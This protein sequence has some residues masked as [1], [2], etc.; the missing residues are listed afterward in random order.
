MVSAQRDALR[1]KDSVQ[2]ED[3]DLSLEGGRDGIHSKGSLQIKGGHIRIKAA[4]YGLYAFEEIMAREPARLE[5]EPPLSQF[6]CKGPIQIEEG[7]GQ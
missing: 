6:G 1:G 3:G 5:M 4:R 2:I 7:V